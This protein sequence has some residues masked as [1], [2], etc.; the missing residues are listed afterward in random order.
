M[1]KL[2][3]IN[4]TVICE[5]KQK[6]SCTVE[7]GVKLSEVS[8]W[9]VGG[10]A[11][12]IVAPESMEQ[13]IQ[14]RQYIYQHQLPYLVIGNTTNLLFTDENIDAIFIHIG[15]NFSNVQIKDDKIIA[16][17]GVW[18]PRLARI[19]MT[20]GLSGLE[21]TCGIPGTLGGLIVM[22]GGSQRKGIGSSIESVTTL[23]ERGKIKSYS[24]NQ[25]DFGYRKSVFQT[26]REIIVQAALRL[27][28]TRNKNAIR[29]EMIDILRSRNKKFPRKMAQC[30]SVFVSNPAM[31]KK[32][33]APGKVIEDCGLKGYQWGGAQ[34][35][36]TH[37]NFIVNNGT[38]KATDILQLIEQARTIVKEKTG[39]EMQV[40]TSFVNM[41]GKVLKI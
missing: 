14:L 4:S 20:A 39:Y 22:N 36:T 31:Y 24:R 34:I 10:R 1:N 30:G 19:A 28:T 38:A 8:Q 2:R 35:S 16:E 5:L 29:R 32:Y 26:K 18:V 12:V 3:T 6:L 25:C 15:E 13:F 9:K 21:H 7:E 37:A 17:S 40:E 11:A 33:G 23:D 41:S 27:N